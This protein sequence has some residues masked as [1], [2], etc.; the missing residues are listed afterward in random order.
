MAGEESVVLDFDYVLW[1]DDGNVQHI[2]AA[3]LTPEEV[4][5]GS[6][7]TRSRL[8]YVGCHGK[9]GGIGALVPASTLSSCTRSTDRAG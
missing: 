3:G 8:R 5:A 7:L 2:E 4:G 9:A 6:L 1:D